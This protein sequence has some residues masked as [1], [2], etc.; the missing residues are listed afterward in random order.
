[1]DDEQLRAGVNPLV[2]ENGYPL[3]STYNYCVL[4]KQVLMILNWSEAPWICFR[5]LA[6]NVLY[7]YKK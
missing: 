2:L 6:R 1:M 3:V 7:L 4:K 5:F